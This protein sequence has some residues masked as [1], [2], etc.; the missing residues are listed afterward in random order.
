MASLSN[1]NLQHNKESESWPVPLRSLRT[2]YLP[3]PFHD[4]IRGLEGC[5][6]LSKHNF[7]APLRNLKI[8]C[9]KS[10]S[11]L[12]HSRRYRGLDNVRPAGCS[13]DSS[14]KLYCEDVELR[15]NCL[16]IK[17]LGVVPSL[18]RHSGSIRYSRGSSRSTEVS[19]G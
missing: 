4:S 9:G 1:E 5:F 15:F 8:L 10:W 7:H 13:V 3:L 2:T 12:V 19:T 14:N 17:Y 11:V 6:M 16:V 18:V